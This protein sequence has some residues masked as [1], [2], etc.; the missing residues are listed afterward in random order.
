M[1]NIMIVELNG[2]GFGVVTQS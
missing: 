2:F 1:W